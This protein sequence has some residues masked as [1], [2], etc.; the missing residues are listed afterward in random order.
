MGVGLG[1]GVGGDAG[2]EGRRGF[3]IAWGIVGG[4]LVFGVSGG[5]G[6]ACL[7]ESLRLEELREAIVDWADGADV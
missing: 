5:R 6:C 7:I 2:A 3:G 1:A 4:M